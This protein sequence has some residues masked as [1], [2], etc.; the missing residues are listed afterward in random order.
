M[1]QRIL[2]EIGDGA[3]AQLGFGNFKQLLGGAINES[4]ASIEAGGDDA[5]AHRLHD[6]LVQRLQVF[7]RAAR[8]FQLHI[9]LAQL[10]HEQAGQVGDGEV[11]EQVDEDNDLERFEL[12]MG[13]GVRGNDEI[14]IEFENGSEKDEGERGAQVSPDTGQE[15]AGDD[16]DERVKKIERAVDAA[17][18]M[19]DQ[20]NHGQIGEHLQDGLEAMLVS[21]PK[22]EKE[23]RARART[24]A[25]CR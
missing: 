5:A 10:A 1:G 7:E 19:D 17:G 9:D 18:D 24:R 3:P 2:K 13:S 25:P 20:G 14:V 11:G 22:P 15:H 16:N 6:I 4:D 8:V 23:R 12:G 21:R